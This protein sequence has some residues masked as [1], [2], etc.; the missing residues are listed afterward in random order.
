MICISVQKE[1]NCTTVTIDGQMAGSDVAELGRLRRSVSGTTVL[2]LSGLDS[3]VADGIQVL[4]AWLAAGARLEAATP[5][6]RMLL[7]DGKN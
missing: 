2:N 6:L 1:K 5:Y 3:C 4:R 7:Q